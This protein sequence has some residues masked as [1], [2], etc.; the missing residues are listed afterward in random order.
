[1]AR[2]KVVQS[3][4]KSLPQQDIAVLPEN[5]LGKDILVGDLHG[6]DEMLM[7]LISSL[8]DNDRLI[9]VGDLTDRGKGS[10]DVVK[11]II[12]FNRQRKKAGLPEIQ[13]I[14]GNHE[15]IFLDYYHGKSKH[16]LNKDIGG[17]WAL[18]CSPK[19]LK[20]VADFYSSLPYIV[21]V[22]GADPF[23]VVHADMPI[24]DEDL[25]ERIRNHQFMLSDTE[26]HHA[27]W[28]REHVDILGTGRDIHSILTYCGH[29][30]G[31]GVRTKS[32]HINLDVAAYLMNNVCM[33]EHQT[34]QV[35]ILGKKDTRSF[36]LG[37][38][39]TVLDIKNEIELYFLFLATL[40]KINEIGS[41]PALAQRVRK[42]DAEIIELMNEYRRRGHDTNGVYLNVLNEVLP[43]LT[44]DMQTSLYDYILHH[45][46]SVKVSK[47]DVM[48][49]LLNLEKNKDISPHEKAKQL[50]DYL[51]KIAFMPNT[52]GRN[53]QTSYLIAL[54][55]VAPLFS[56][57][58]KEA[59]GHYL[60]I[61]K[62]HKLAET[63]S[64]RM[65]VIN[66][67]AD[68]PNDRSKYYIRK[69]LSILD[70]TPVVHD[71][72]SDYYTRS[73]QILLEQYAALPPCSS[74]EDLELSA[75]LAKIEA[76]H[77]D[78][79][80]RYDALREAW[81]SGWESYFHDVPGKAGTRCVDII[82]QTIETFD[83]ELGR[84]SL[85][86]G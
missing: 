44:S 84:S 54:R 34:K 56:K 10:L 79:M 5:V 69:A 22:E 45:R 39:K 75:K 65:F 62:T 11:T 36:D 81:N 68:R 32:K 53:V 42:I 50:N 19:D 17:H 66:E 80:A 61:S 12:E 31:E 26:K 13:V 67:S 6:N 24:T 14:R 7:L 51:L 29:S 70:V 30:I 59:L 16:L 49:I 71:K 1:M 18:D 9:I 48:T 73:K 85:R 4:R 37:K 35:K 57:Q 43:K 77:V 64:H 20:L 23:N 8:E 78:P 2:D 3:T 41:S 83:T 74:L 76:N 47:D 33:V 52:F 15:S 27:T 63:D 40:K 38:Q 60:Q 46:V 25:L 28:A 58:T 86:L 72:G 55:E 82:E 21:H